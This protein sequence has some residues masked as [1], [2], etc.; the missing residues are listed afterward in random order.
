MATNDL[1]MAMSANGFQA[2]CVQCLYDEYAL[3][4]RVSLEGKRYNA[5]VV[6]GGQ[7]LCAKHFVEVLTINLESRKK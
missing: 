4:G 1:S 7:S 5:V 2:F 3:V 6:Y